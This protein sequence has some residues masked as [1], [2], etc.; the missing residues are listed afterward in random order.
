MSQANFRAGPTFSQRYRLLTA[1]A[2]PDELG[3]RIRRQG[4]VK[5]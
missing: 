2:R 5:R 4:V 1:L 3:G